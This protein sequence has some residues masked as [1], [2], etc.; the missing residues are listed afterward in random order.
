MIV[1]IFEF[2]A[3]HF[4]PKY[5]GPCSN[6][7]GHSY[8]LEIGFSGNS[9]HNGMIMDFSDLKKIVQDEIIQHLDHKL[10]N[11]CRMPG[12]NWENPTAEHM[13]DWMNWKLNSQSWGGVSATF[14][15]LWETS[16]SYA[17]WRV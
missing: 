4:L 17:E 10:L 2:E 13:V 8:K 1:K 5:V 14:I 6:M 9:L 7:H 11:E 3:A 12:F 16:T 15:R